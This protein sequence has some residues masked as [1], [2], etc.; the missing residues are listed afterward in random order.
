MRIVRESILTPL[1]IM[2]SWDLSGYMCVCDANKAI[3]DKKLWVLSFCIYLIGNLA[4]NHTY[5][6]PSRTRII[7]KLPVPIKVAISNHYTK[8]VVLMFDIYTPKIISNFD[9]RHAEYHSQGFPDLIHV[10]E[11][12]GYLYKIKSS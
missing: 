6:F 7:M 9:Q 12:N 2:Y 3:N 11:E 5:P 8:A 10:L 4:Y 1:C